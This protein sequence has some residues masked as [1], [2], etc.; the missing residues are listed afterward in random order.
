[1]KGFSD[2]LALDAGLEPELEVAGDLFERFP[3]VGRVLEK[4]PVRGVV[5][6]EIGIRAKHGNGR[7]SHLRPPVEPDRR[8]AQVEG[9]GCSRSWMETAPWALGPLSDRATIRTTSG[10]AHAIFVPTPGSV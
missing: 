1:M 5:E 10:Q 7:L 9:G 3:G 6:I 2:Q 4:R 8:R